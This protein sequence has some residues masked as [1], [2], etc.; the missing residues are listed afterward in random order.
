MLESCLRLSKCSVMALL[1][2]RQAWSLAALFVLFPC[3]FFASDTSDRPATTY[4]TRTSEVLVSLF[5]TDEN[6][7]PVEALN[8]DD[9]AVVDGDLV[10]RDFR[11]L[12][13]SNETALDI[14][15]LVDASASVASGFQA[16][17]G[18]VLRLVSQNLASDDLSVV[19]FAG[20]QPAVLCTGNCRSAG[21]QSRL[22]A[23]KATGATPLFDA[24]VYTARFAAERRRPGARQIL[25]LFSDGNDT[26]SITS[27]RE[28]LDTVVD[29]GSILY[30]ITPSAEGSRESASLQSMAE[31]TGGRSFHLKD[32]A[33]KILEGVLEDQRAC[34]IVTYELPNHQPGFHS[35]RILPKHNL[36][37]RF[38]CRKG[39]YYEDLR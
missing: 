37:L 4:R 23:V 30:T 11:S 34:Y 18:N 6:N 38:H 20:L 9:F 3:I 24:L 32:G 33:D 36:K 29:S 15:V 25:I 17:M 27:A 16:T 12:V 35:L 10:I 14:V 19:T 7:R 26:I 5:A 39:Y 28:A 1:S 13:R 31:A 21:S 8:K 22:L 2:H